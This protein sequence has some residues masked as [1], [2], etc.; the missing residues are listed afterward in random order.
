MRIQT[1]HGV[2]IQ[3]M[4]L[5]FLSRIHVILSN[6]D[7]MKLRYKL[8]VFSLV[9]CVMEC[10]SQTIS[11]QASGH[12]YVDLGLS[13][14]WATYNVGATKPEDNGDC[15]AWGE[16]KPK[17]EYSRKTYKWTKDEGKTFIKY[18]TDRR[19]GTI[20][21]KMVLEPE[22]DAATSNWGSEWRMPTLDEIKELIDGCG[23]T[24][25]YNYC[26]SGVAGRIGTSTIN[27]NKIFL[28]AVCWCKLEDS[29]PCGYESGDYWTSSLQG[30]S[31]VADCLILY[32][33]L[34]DWY[35]HERY[36]G[37]NV[38]AVLR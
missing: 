30:D 28:P 5:L 25:T 22:D 23:W 16:T 17:E 2:K 12:E 13:V 35:E 31:Y 4:E 26:G 10:S 14:K 21:N 38:R 20:D 29:A 37:K 1:S 7:M 3:L 33:D 27:G 19:F 8:I 11:G 18:V 6:K 32:V 36:I 24:W 34:I 15:F 9:M